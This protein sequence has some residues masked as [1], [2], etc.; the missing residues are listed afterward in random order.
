VAGS[1]SA[2]AAGGT[3]VGARSAGAACG[4]SPSALWR[5]QY[6]PSRSTTT[7]SRLCQ[8]SAAPG[9]RASGA[10]S[11]SPATQAAIRR[12]TPSSGGGG[13]LTWRY[14]TAIG[15]SDGPNGGAPL[16]S[17]KAMTPRA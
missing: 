17:S 4:T 3:T 13:S 9:G 11:R 7:S 6:G 12:S 16:T 5:R 2:A 15:V 1:G 8:A 14:M 10:F